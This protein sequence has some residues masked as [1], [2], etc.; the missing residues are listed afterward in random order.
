M[1]H[2]P[3]TPLATCI[4]KRSAT[5][6]CTIRLRMLLAEKRRVPCA[7]VLQAHE[8]RYICELASPLARRLR[9]CCM[10]A[11]SVCPSTRTEVVAVSICACLPIL[12]G[13]YSRMELKEVVAFGQPSTRRD[14]RVRFD[15]VVCRIEKRHAPC[16]KPRNDARPSCS[17]QDAPVQ[18]GLWLI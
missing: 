18:A 14:R 6:R 12:R 15:C 5:F 11:W 17:R 3:W 10:L 4:R 9:A 8:G 2:P 13:Q 16:V 1:E 7:Q